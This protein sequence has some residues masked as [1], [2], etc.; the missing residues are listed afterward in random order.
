MN[1]YNTLVLSISSEV[2]EGIYH[3][4]TQKDW[5]VWVGKHFVNF[6]DSDYN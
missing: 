2:L 3:T 1:Q 4:K 5:G 6:L